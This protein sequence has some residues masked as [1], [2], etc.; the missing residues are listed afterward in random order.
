MCDDKK[1]KEWV[2]LAL[3]N[4]DLADYTIDVHGQASKEDGYLGNIIFVT[5]TG[6]TKADTE[7]SL[8]FVI[9][10]SK[11]SLDLRNQAP[12]KEAFEKEIF[13]YDE[14]KTAF[15]DFQ[16]DKGVEKL[17][18][19]MP[20]CYATRITDTG[21]LLI[22]EN[23]RPQGYSLWDRKVPMTF[24]QV[25]MILKMYGKWHAIC[26]AFRKQRPEIFRKFVENNVNV[27]SCFVSKT[28]MVDYFAE[29]FASVRDA[30][31]SIDEIDV[32]KR[33]QF[34]KDDVKYI[35]TDM[36]FDDPDHHVILHGDC[37][38]NNFLFKFQD[39]S[40]DIM[41]V[42]IIDWQCSGLGSPAIDLSDF[43]YGCCD[44]EN[45][46][47]VKELLTIYYSS[48]SEYLKQ[49]GSEP[50]EVFPFGKLL[51]HWKKFSKF[52]ILVSAFNLKFCLCEADDAPDFAQTA[53][54]G[55]TFIDN[56][57]FNLKNEDDY[58]ERMKSNLI[59]YANNL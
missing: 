10:S 50:E 3:K 28:K 9:K 48:F 16:H 11:E 12:I 38:N 22:L 31:I 47:D 45:H 18:E 44:I 6:K 32:L 17:L 41:D 37:W 8:N 40:T 55:M 49:L 4:Q 58:L 36:Y 19:I 20:H 51:E 52:G 26:M 54:Q 2:K 46:K 25:K 24:A 33:L 34:S 15:D 30:V 27:F 53:E 14:V 21:E 23:L 56:F 42:R 29:L 39:N 7:K 5:V 13:I 59:H 1:I 35:L 43:I 57:N